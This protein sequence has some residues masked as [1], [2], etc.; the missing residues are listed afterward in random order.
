MFIRLDNIINKVRLFLSI[1]WLRR[2]A[3]SVRNNVCV[4]LLDSGRGNE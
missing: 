1:L 4:F 3:V 2:E